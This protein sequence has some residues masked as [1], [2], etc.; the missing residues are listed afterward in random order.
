[1]GMR[2]K[3]SSWTGR[4]IEAILGAVFASIFLE[5]ALLLGFGDRLPAE[6][7]LRNVI[8]MVLGILIAMIV[9]MVAYVSRYKKTF[10][11]TM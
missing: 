4:V 2:G 7:F 3:V 1:M 8:F 9:I 5:V 6:G 10:T 11:P